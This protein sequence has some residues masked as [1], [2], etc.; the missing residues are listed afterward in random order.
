M[1]SIPRPRREINSDEAE[2]RSLARHRLPGEGPYRSVAII[3]TTTAS[4]VF[5]GDGST[6]PEADRNLYLKVRRFLSAV[7]TV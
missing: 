6:R 1:N 7:G 3:R 2:C 5:R 4:Y